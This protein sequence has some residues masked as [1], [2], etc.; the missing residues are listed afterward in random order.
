[1]SSWVKR[2]LTDN[3]VVELNPAV[4]APLALPLERNFVAA[5]AAEAAEAV[6][7]AVSVPIGSIGRAAGVCLWRLGA[8]GSEGA[9]PVTGTASARVRGRVLLP[10][11]LSVS[12]EAVTL[13][14]AG[15]GCFLDAAGRRKGVPTP[16][17]AEAALPEAAVAP[18]PTTRT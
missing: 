15:R 16:G 18:S 4:N 12:G 9:S 2:G 10:V 13:G 7:A 11:S 5:S 1:M 17:A 3:L 14:A 8:A 6:A